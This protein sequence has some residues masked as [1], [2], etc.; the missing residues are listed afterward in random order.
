[1]ADRAGVVNVSPINGVTAL[2]TP[3]EADRA[4][5]QLEDE[6]GDLVFEPLSGA[7]GTFAIPELAQILRQRG[8]RL[9]GCRTPC[10]G[11][12]S[13]AGSAEPH[14]GGPSAPASRFR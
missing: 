13:G 6:G 1:M 14:P 3:A 8:Y 10:P 5:D 2:I 11:F 9:G 4:L 7:Q 12:G